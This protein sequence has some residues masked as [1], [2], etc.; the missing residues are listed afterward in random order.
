M[1][2]YKKLIW[3][4]PHSRPGRNV[5][6]VWADYLRE[7]DWDIREEI[8]DE[9]S[10]IYSASE[11]QIEKAFAIQGQTKLPIVCW[12]WGF[13]YFRLADRSG[14][15]ARLYLNK[16]ELLKGCQM[17]LTPSQLGQM[18]LGDWFMLSNIVLPGVDNNL[19]TS[20]PSQE[21]RRQIVYVGRLVPHKRI[22][23]IIEAAKLLGNVEVV[24]IGDGEEKTNL[25]ELAKRLEMKLRI[26]DNFDDTQKIIEIKKSLVLVSASE[27]EGF[28]MPPAEAVLANRPALVRD[29]PFFRIVY[30]DSMLYFEGP[31]D[32]AALISRLHNDQSFY[33][34]VIEIESAVKE[35]YTM[36]LAAKRLDSI[37]SSFLSTNIKEAIGTFVKSA[38]TLE[39]MRNIYDANTKR[40]FDFHADDL[41][42]NKMDS[43]R[44][45][46]IIKELNPGSLLDLGC[47]NGSLSIKF[48]QAGFKVTGIDISALNINFARNFAKKLNL[49]IIYEV[50]V[51]EQLTFADSLFNNVWMGELLEHVLDPKN[52]IK[53]GLRVLKFGGKLAGS[54]PFEYDFTSPLH[55]RTWGFESLKEFLMSFSGVSILKL[56]IIENPYA[57]DQRHLFFILR[58]NGTE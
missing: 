12:C 38:K 20:I 11:S 42:E 37:L 1:G 30:K 47:S 29:T 44:A 8:F 52:V 3:V 27:Y 45:D 50:M 57:H 43:W 32:L 10:L 40:E 15:W 22:D 55:V 56:E 24:L 19:I 18:Q 34:R 7:L 53:S 6:E 41:G 33:D 25:I 39:D 5:A 49:D 58:K 14:T 23:I 31:K 36:T 54:T 51:A 28:G 4:T 16:I 26:E 13:P 2:Y 46:I 9:A 21:I 48:A 35:V 17:L